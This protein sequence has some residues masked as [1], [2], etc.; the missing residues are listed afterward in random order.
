MSHGQKTKRPPRT[1][2]KMSAP[3]THE[4]SPQGPTSLT[5]S[6]L[7]SFGPCVPPL[8]LVWRHLFGPLSLTRSGPQSL[9][10]LSLSSSIDALR[11]TVEAQ[12][13]RLKDV[14][15]GLSEYFDRLVRLED[16]VSHLV[17]DNSKLRDKLDDLEFRSR[18]NN[19]RI[20]NVPE[21]MALDNALA[22]VSSLL[23][24][25]LGPSGVLS[26]APKLG[27]AHRLGR[28][29]DDPT[30]A[31]PRPL[32]CCLHDFQD[33]E[34]ILRRRDK[35]QLFFRGG[36]IFIFPDMISSVSEKRATFLGVKRQLYDRKVR[37]FPEAPSSGVA[38]YYFLLR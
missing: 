28:L 9:T 33:R 29:P 6:P 25:V 38:I 1:P 20:L 7:L 31:R 30:N 3:D 22:F 36:K 17:K 27:R 34:R 15:S 12:G 10:P 5:H 14:E 4:A 23:L 8:R 18:R 13:G 2:A 35:A 24:E 32:I 11:A 19:V 16:T 26:S 21:K 37:F